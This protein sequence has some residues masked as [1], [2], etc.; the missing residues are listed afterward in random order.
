[1]IRIRKGLDVPIAGEPVQAIEDGPPVR[2]VALVADDYIGMRPTMH[3]A[4]GDSVRA[5]QLVFEDK[6]TPGV[7]FTAPG[8]GRVLAVNRGVKRK[9]QSL[10]IEL[11]GDERQR[12]DSYED[13]D[14]TG[15]GREKVERL[16]LDSGLWSAL[17]VRP[18]SKVPVPG[19]RPHS[20][21]VTATDTNP[22]AARPDLVIAEHEL[23][24]L[25]GLQVIRH[26]TEGKVYVC[27]SPDAA[28]SS[29]ELP[30]VEYVD[31][32]GPHPSG[33][34][35][36]HIH[37]LDPVGRRKQVW[38]L[39][40]QDL[41]AVGRLFV[42]GELMTE[43]VV[44]LGGPVVQRPRLIRTR[45]GANLDDLTAGQLNADDVRVISGSPLSGRRS[46]PPANYLGRYHLQV[47]ALREGREREFL[48]WQKPG[49]ETFSITRAFTSAFFGRGKR[50]N[51][52]TSL[53]GSPRPMVPI[54]SYDRVM[55]LDVIPVYLLRS[56]I[57]RDTEQ[58][59]AL[60]CLELDE[61]DLA[62]C[63]FVCPGKYE[64]GPILRENLKIIEKEG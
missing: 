8:S 32:A 16:L 19:R 56:L 21:F 44:A 48:G 22:L 55:P 2:T 61:E 52:T 11:D 20:I 59:Q 63:T 27:K 62:L 45:L 30:F 15:L 3:V 13:V 9:F 26:L 33:L 34:V 29:P 25:Y 47:S 31:F 60:G 49:W 40:Y 46:E 64:Y 7:R 14:L 1:M 24:F 39:N 43:R 36:T 37:F 17:R 54:D 4:E 12:F 50:F 53:G 23:D 10:V 58:A 6:K 5:G 18:F 42:T 38:H 57:V 41:I 35:G 28:L 51:L